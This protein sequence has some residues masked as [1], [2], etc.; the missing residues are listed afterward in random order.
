MQLG[1]YICTASSQRLRFN[2]SLRTTSAPSGGTQLLQFTLLFPFQSTPMAQ[3][4]QCSSAGGALPTPL[5]AV[6]WEVHTQRIAP[7]AT[8]HHRAGWCLSCAAPIDGD[9]F[10]VKQRPPHRWW[11]TLREFHGS[12]HTQ[13]GGTWPLH[14]ASA[15][16]LIARI[17]PR[18]AAPGTA[19]GSRTCPQPHGDHALPPCPAAWGQTDGHT[20]GRRGAVGAAG[21]HAD[22]CPCVRSGRA[23][24][25][26]Q[27]RLL[28]LQERGRGSS[29]V[30]V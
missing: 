13:A 28:S 3:M 6:P 9:G 19:P 8:P 29:A 5:G 21:A 22:V 12:I 1:K 25:V 18:A 11:H 10:Q 30:P 26:S 4:E 15:G 16:Y 20:W 14:S 23:V 7:H 24:G 17:G 2:P 27:Q